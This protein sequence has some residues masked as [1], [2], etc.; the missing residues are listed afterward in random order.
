MLN[1]MCVDGGQDGLIDKNEFSEMV[2]NLSFITNIF[3]GAESGDSLKD[4]LTHIQ[5]DALLHHPWKFR[6]ENE[7]DHLAIVIKNIQAQNQLANSEKN[8]H[9]QKGKQE[10]GVE[11]G[12]EEEKRRIELMDLKSRNSKLNKVLE[13]ARKLK[14]LGLLTYINPEWGH[15]A[16]ELEIKA[17]RR[18]GFA[19]TAYNVEFW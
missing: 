15:G 11:K 10:I 17:I 3:T 1:K 7:S 6:E 13:T 8:Q 5:L 18:V 14:S 16:E 19:F 9:S 12:T 2:K 4:N